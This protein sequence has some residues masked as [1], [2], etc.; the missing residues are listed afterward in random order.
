MPPSHPTP[1]T[2]APPALRRELR[3]T[4]TGVA[5]KV[6][7]DRTRR[8]KERAQEGRD[9]KDKRALRHTMETMVKQLNGF[10]DALAGKTK[11]ARKLQARLA[12][13]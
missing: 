5:R 10:A 4:E 11:E 12:R 1:A 6:A 2:K 8:R 9:R 7:Q 13:P 3:A